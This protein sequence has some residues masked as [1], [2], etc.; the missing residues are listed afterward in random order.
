MSRWRIPLERG[1]REYASLGWGSQVTVL[2]AF[3]AFLFLGGALAWGASIK[4]NEERAAKARILPPVTVDAQARTRTLFLQAV[5][6]A[7][8][9]AGV[10]HALDAASGT[11]RV[12][13]GSVSF[14]VG[15]AWLLGR[16]LEEVDKIG[17]VLAQ[18]L[19]C[20]PKPP[21][22]YTAPDV[23]HLEQAP[24]MQGC[25]LQEAL[26]VPEFQCTRE[27]SKLALEAILVEGHADA[28]P[29]PAAGKRNKDNLSLSSARGETVLRRLYAC[30]P[31]LAG[32]SNARGLPLVGVGGHSTQRPVPESDPNAES[33]R[34]VEFRFILGT[35]AQ[36]R[37]IPSGSSS[38]MESTTKSGL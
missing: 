23:A 1:D 13:P 34:R 6:S 21:S 12:G 35:G 37:Q 33:N 20:L 15:Q 3:S 31:A 28:R 11:L 9:G 26:G 16:P 24:G 14:K 30:H 10:D 2:G 5:S 17:V 32:F 25:S 29:F 22:T 27:F 8:Q 7:L 36:G 4:G 18:A 38:A 19:T